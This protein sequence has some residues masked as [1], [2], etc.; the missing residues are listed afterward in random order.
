[1]DVRAVEAFAALVPKE[2]EVVCRPVVERRRVSK[3]C[4]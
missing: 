2:E 1:M 3:N 4:G